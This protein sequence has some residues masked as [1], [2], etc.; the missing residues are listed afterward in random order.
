MYCSQ[1][2]ENTTV[3]QRPSLVQSLL[4]Q[5]VII[6]KRTVDFLFR[7]RLVIPKNFLGTKIGYNAVLND[8]RKRNLARRRLTRKRMNILGRMN[9]NRHLWPVT[10]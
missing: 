5:A 2:V 7:P 6:G 8:F 1:Q 9:K 3:M 4:Q 10:H